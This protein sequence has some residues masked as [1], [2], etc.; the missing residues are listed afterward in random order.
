M[1]LWVTLWGELGCAFTD[2]TLT[3]NQTVRTAYW[4][5]KCIKEANLPPGGMAAVGM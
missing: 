2:G 3:A 1:G 4:R 5:G